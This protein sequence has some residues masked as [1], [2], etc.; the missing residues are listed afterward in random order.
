MRDKSP[1][2]VYR[3][4]IAEHLSQGWSAWFDGIMI[5]DEP[6]GETSLTAKLDQPR[7]HAVLNRIRDLNLVLLSVERL[8]HK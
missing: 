5:A 8:E 2:A 4:C 6:E 3:I 1:E 7:L